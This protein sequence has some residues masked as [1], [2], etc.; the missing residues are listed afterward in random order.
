MGVR[1]VIV[2][3]L[4]GKEHRDF[5]AS[6]SRQRASLH[7]LPPF[8]VLVLDGAL[9]RPIARPVAAILEALAGRVVA[10]SVD[11]PALVFDEPDVTI[12]PTP[13][14]HVRVRSGDH[15]GEEGR[16]AGLAGVRRVAG[17]TFLEAGWVVV[18]GRAPIAVPIADLERFA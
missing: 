17:G 8:A 13:P 4:G 10:I 9:R 7:Q 5:L 6:E 1:G 15:A 3:G 11:P 14:D 2:S 12:P 18:G 16:W